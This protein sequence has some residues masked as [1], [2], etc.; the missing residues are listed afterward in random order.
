MGEKTELR[1]ET[2]ASAVRK[3]ATEERDRY[4]PVQEFRLAVVMYGGISLA[5]YMNGVAQEMLSLV[6]ATAPSPDDP[7]A[8]LLKTPPQEGAAKLEADK[9]L[10]GTERVYRDLGRLL[11]HDRER[12]IT[13]SAG[14]ANEPVHTRFVVDILSGTSAGGIN[15]VFLAR[16]LANNQSMEG[17]KKLWVREGDLGRLLNDGYALPDSLLNSDRMYDQLLLALKG[18]DETGPS[19][20]NKPPFAPDLCDSPLVEEMDLFVTTTDVQGL[21]MPIRLADK[22]IRE[23]R[24]RNVF[25]FR[26]GLPE[27]GETLRNDFHSGNTPFLAYAARCTSAFPFAFEPMCLET[28]SRLSGVQVNPQWADFYA[29]YIRAEQRGETGALQFPQRYFIDGGCLDNKPFSYAIEALRWRR[30]GIPV[31][32][33]LFYIEPSPEHPEQTPD[34]NQKP[35]ALGTVYAGYMDLPH[36]ENI[37][38]DLQILLDRNRLIERVQQVMDNVDVEVAA[39]HSPEAVRQN[40]ER[41]A[42]QT[43]A[44]MLQEKGEAGPAYAAYYRL[45]VSAVTDN[46]ARIL[47]C[48]AGFDDNSDE[49][50]AVRYL[51]TAWRDASYPEEPPPAPEG[52][53]RPT[54]NRFLLNYDL[55][56]RIRRLNFARKKVDEL[57][58][59]TGE[60]TDRDERSAR[61][62]AL[63]AL[64]KQLNAIRYGLLGLH[65]WL[66]SPN[67][68][69]VPPAD[70]KKN[71]L[72]DFMEPL[73]ARVSLAAILNPPDGRT[74]QE[75]A[76]RIYAAPDNRAVMDALARKLA[77]VLKNGSQLSTF[78]FQLS[79]LNLKT[80]ARLGLGA[81][82]KMARE[83]LAEGTG[84]LKDARSRSLTDYFEGFEKYDFV[85]FPILYGTGVG[86]VRPVGVVRI[87]PEDAVSVADES[88]TGAMKLAGITLGHFGAFLSPLWRE[89]DILW[90]RLDGAER[91]IHGLAPHVREE[92]RLALVRDAHCEILADTFKVSRAEAQTLYARMTGD[93]PVPELPA[94][95]AGSDDQPLISDLFVRSVRLGAAKGLGD[96]PP[97]VTVNLLTRSTHVVGRMLEKISWNR[98]I[99]QFWV[100]IPARIGA[101]VCGM[102]N[103]A[104][105]NSLWNIL[106]KHWFKLL[107]LFETLLIVGGTIIGGQSGI[108][109]R[110][111]GL[112]ML[113]LTLGFHIGVFFLE[114]YMQGRGGFRAWKHWLAVFLFLL[115]LLVFVSGLLHVGQDLWNWGNGIVKSVRGIGRPAEE[116]F[117]SRYTRE[118]ENR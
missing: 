88:R 79:T 118:A 105:P 78:D 102:A 1:E 64:K 99:K 38:D 59:A 60:M 92:T 114:R 57:Y 110:T 44:E 107:Y 7:N 11:G 58:D 32:R 76:R 35:D 97:K 8:L 117:S 71:P 28:A 10:C 31:K 116:G 50:L 26:Y 93:A 6:R 96:L 4:D 91:I 27:D 94:L 100:T 41:W 72:T 54:R 84:S 77:E 82:S 21:V 86:E 55:D 19:A 103:V 13:G 30:A 74:P 48:A 14:L 61:R 75:E 85:T 89:N 18:M 20:R 24:Y 104:T 51:V 98:D 17:L 62:S 67:R 12:E 36:V 49:F 101:I 23:R 90:G 33:T 63:S 34:R 52:A 47:T 65:A 3:T 113:G 5:I 29:D 112:E 56:Y 53:E 87:S 111:F 108:S 22:T 106:V 73:K 40:A 66:S 15:G 95:P 115:A 81:A 43:V 80:P 45:K 68:D 109:A 83:A 46:I 16:A 42:N 69:S 9:Y 2:A 70:R 25:R 37:R 39:Q